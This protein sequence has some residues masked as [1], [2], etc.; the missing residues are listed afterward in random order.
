MKVKLIPSVVGTGK[1]VDE[2]EIRRRIE[3]IQTNALLRFAGVIMSLGDL[4]SLAV[5]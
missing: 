2:R 3:T 1:R 4:G 5:P